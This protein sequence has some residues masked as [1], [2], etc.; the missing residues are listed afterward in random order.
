MVAAGRSRSSSAL[1]VTWT[2]LKKKK[3]T[4]TFQGW[5]FSSTSR[6]MLSFPKLKIHHYQLLSQIAFQSY[7]WDGLDEE[8]L[9]N[10]VIELFHK[11]EDENEEYF[12]L[13]NENNLEYEIRLV[14]DEEAL[15]EKREV[16]S[17]ELHVG[18]DQVMV[19]KWVG[20]QE[21]EGSRSVRTFV[22]MALMARLGV[23]EELVANTHLCEV[24]RL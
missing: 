23:I 6:Y 20:G 16:A 1:E 8:A 19:E 17:D 10:L 24:A 5:C 13:W 15:L 2:P 22:A 9:Q 14:E 3:T 18:E 11:T 12:Y 7:A 4:S 21:E